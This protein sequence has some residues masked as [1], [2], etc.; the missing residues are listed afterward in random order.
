MWNFSDLFF[1]HSLI[2]WDFPTPDSPTK[3]II[4]LENEIFA[5]KDAVSKRLS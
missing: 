1:K 5:E 3:V 4:L 2:Q